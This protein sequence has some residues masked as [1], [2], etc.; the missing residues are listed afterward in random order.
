M[1]IACIDTYLSHKLS[2]VPRL[3]HRLIPRGWADN[4]SA[5][6]AVRGYAPT[7][8]PQCSVSF[9]P[10]YGTLLGSTRSNC[11]AL[12]NTNAF[13]TIVHMSNTPAWTATTTTAAT[14]PTLKIYSAVSKHR[15]HVP[16]DP[17]KDKG[18]LGENKRNRAKRA[19]REGEAAAKLDPLGVLI[20]GKMPGLNEG[21]IMPM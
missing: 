13:G 5:Q 17:F 2:S 3:L 18:P 7:V 14:T 21:K 1:R 6:D 9:T 10:C 16:W 19:R 4:D 8:Y 12:Q 20:M 15:S 11:Q